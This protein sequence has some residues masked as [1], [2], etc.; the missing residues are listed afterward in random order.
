MKKIFQQ[1]QQEAVKIAKRYPPPDFYLDYA[2]QVEYSA[3]FFDADPLVCRLREYVVDSIEDDY[4]HGIDHADKVALDAGSLMLIEGE[5]IGYSHDF[6][7]HSIR[8]AQCAGLLHDLK[9]KT[10]N[11]AQE[12]AAFAH[13]VLSQYPLPPKDVSA[14]CVAIRNHEAFGERERSGNREDLLLSN[15]LYDSDKFRWGPDNFTQT[16]WGMVSYLNPSI[17]AFAGHYPKGM[18][19]LNKIKNTFRTNTGRAYGPQF[20]DLGLAIGEELYTYIRTEFAE[21]IESSIS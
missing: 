13:G 20:I 17:Q 12:G 10:Q 14:V 5:R 1:I 8:L 6:L 3:R 21:E 18:A 15:C 19:Y 2:D 9:R 4:G 7:V 11:H 16:V